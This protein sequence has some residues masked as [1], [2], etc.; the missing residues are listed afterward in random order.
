MRVVELSN[1][2]NWESIYTTSVTG[3]VLYTEEGKPVPV[4]IPPVDIPFLLESFIFAISVA[5]TVPEDATWRFAGYVNQKISTGVV[6][7]GSQDATFNKSQALFLDQ[8]NLV[9]FPKVSATYSLSINLPRWFLDAQIIVWRYTG[10]DDTS[11]EILLTQE[12][13]NLNFKLDQLVS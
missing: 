2:A 1:N 13:A 12:F 11:E 7:G 8:N 6:L 4:P 3:A 10:I 9:M 5:T